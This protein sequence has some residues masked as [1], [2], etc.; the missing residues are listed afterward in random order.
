METKNTNDLDDIVYKIM[1]RGGKG[2][3]NIVPSLQP[4]APPVPV[5]AAPSAMPNPVPKLESVPAHTATM[6]K[7]DL[8][9]HDMDKADNSF[10]L[11]ASPR[12]SKFVRFAAIAIILLLLI[13]GGVY[14]YFK[15][16]NKT[17]TSGSAAEILKKSNSPV[18]S[19]ITDEWRQKYFNSASCVD[20]S[21]C[22]D[23]ADPDHDGLTNAQEFKALT[24]PNNA[25]SDKD[26]IADGDEVNI[27]HYNPQN[28]ITSG[29]IKYDDAAEARAKYNAS[30]A[31]PF[32]DEELTAIALNISKFGLHEPTITTLGPDLTAQYTNFG[33]SAIVVPDPNAASSSASAAPEAGALDR[34]TQRADTIRQIGFALL[35][36]KQSN[37][38]FPVTS[39]FDDMIK[40]IKPLIQSKAINTTDPKNTAPYVYSYASVSGGSDFKLGYYSETQNQ[41]ITIN[42]KDVT[43]TYNKQQ[44]S[45]RDTQRKA[46]LETIA[47]I[48]ENFSV[49]NANP[50]VP[51]EKIY[52]D[53][54]TWKTD[55][56]P[57][58]ITALPQDPQTKQDYI[59][60]VSQ[61]K[62][63][64]ALQAVLENPP[65]GKKG[66][67]CTADGCTYY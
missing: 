36:Y 31:K 17:S 26:G 66:Y 6:T 65:T 63:T 43:A 58:Y 33:R 60:T 39:I 21:V 30:T 8:V 9:D 50:N 41:V 11:H 24:D 16:F 14:G 56:A 51:N 34:D 23:D 67:A 46:D 29:N 1:P 13:G 64:Y 49:D 35:Q 25:D 7:E 22:G 62:D 32:T 28:S 61:N 40:A 53:Q 59:Y 55:L 42:L 48:L 10:D 5:Q 37:P 4:V 2:G 3:S 15:F 57:K 45:Q 52:P 47:S 19:V 18:A 12:K 27:F 54:A 20:V 44:S 38:K